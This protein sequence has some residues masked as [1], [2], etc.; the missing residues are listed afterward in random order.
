MIS[1]IE[2]SL[3]SRIDPASRRPDSGP[4]GES[5]CNMFFYYIR[6]LTLWQVGATISGDLLQDH[7]EYRSLSI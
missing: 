4:Q 1:E 2:D 5:Q 3:S 7:G 6:S